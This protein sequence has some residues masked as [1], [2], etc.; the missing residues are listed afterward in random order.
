MTNLGINVSVA[1][2]LRVVD[3]GQVLEITEVVELVVVSHDPLDLDLTPHGGPVLRGLD[4]RL[5]LLPLDSDQ[6]GGVRL[7]LPARWFTEHVIWAESELQSSVWLLDDLSDG[8][9]AAKT[10]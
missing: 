3:H 7:L 6:E 8:L 9:Q 1:V 2:L 10:L 4:A 5:Q